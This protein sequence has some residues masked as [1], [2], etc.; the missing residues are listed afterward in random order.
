MTQLVDFGASWSLDLETE[1]N[2]TLAGKPVHRI[3]L[4][5]DTGI[6]DG[7][8]DFFW[9]LPEDE[10]VCFCI[11]GESNVDDIKRTYAVEIV[12]CSCGP[13]PGNTDCVCI[14]AD[15]LNLDNVLCKEFV[16]H[17]MA[18]R[19]SQLGIELR[20]GI[21]GNAGGCGGG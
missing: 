5:S 17:M 13:L 6:G 7:D 15:Q 8:K 2:S 14:K 18:A 3:Y 4:K 21:D 12:G 9:L 20:M 10:K 11:P 19:A 1:K 16:Q